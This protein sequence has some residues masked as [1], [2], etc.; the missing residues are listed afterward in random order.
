MLELGLAAVLAAFLAAVWQYVVLNL[1]LKETVN[2][3]AQCAS[4][5]FLLFSWL[6]AA[7]ALYFS[8]SL[9]ILEKRF[10]SFPKLVL[11]LIFSS[12]LIALGAL[13]AW[14][15]KDLFVKWNLTWFGQ[16]ER[17]MSGNSRVNP[18][19]SA[20]NTSDVSPSRPQGQAGMPSGHTCTVA[21]CL[22]GVALLLQHRIAWVIF[23]M[24]VVILMAVC[25]VLA[26]C[27]TVPQTVVG[28][29]LGITVGSM[30]SGVV[31]LL[32]KAGE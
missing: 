17:P 3:R 7:W 28:G 11:P 15:A 23:S 12:C 29:V 13:L 9:S 31:S 16:I 4:L 22:F 14:V 24:A 6:I 30:I 1:V 8:D 19:C 2:K 32:L 26:E 20:L 5:F 21:F 10:D 27:H 18:Y 25:R